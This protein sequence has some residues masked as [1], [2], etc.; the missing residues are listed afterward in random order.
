MQNQTQLDAELANA[1]E[2]FGKNIDLASLAQSLGM[3]QSD[4]Q[5]ALGP[6]VQKLAQENTDAGLS[7]Q[8][9]LDQ[10]NQKATQQ[11]IANLNKRGLLHS[12]E[13]GYELN[14]QNLGYRQAQSDAYQKFLGYLQQYQQ[15]YLAAQQANAQKLA[16][17]YNA[18][19]D[20]QYNN[21]QSTP[22]VRMTWAYTDANGNQVYK[23][24][25]GNFFNADGSAYSGPGAP[26]PPPPPPP[27]TTSLRLPTYSGGGGGR[28]M[29]AI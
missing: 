25:S 15:G 4:L 16:D 5:N 11:I 29:L 7:T 22:G 24:A 3:T 23:D 20:R 9:R 26:T 21:N 19:G 14:Q 8:A 18:A 12:G 10:A 1:Y 28:P 2:S 6:D 27:P 13:A 17:A